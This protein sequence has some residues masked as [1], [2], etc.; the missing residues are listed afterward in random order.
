MCGSHDVCLLIDMQSYAIFQSGIIKVHRSACIDILRRMLLSFHRPTLH[1]NTIADTW[2]VKRTF[3]YLVHSEILSLNLYSRLV[4]GSI[5]SQRI[6]GKHVD[7]REYSHGNK[8]WLLLEENAMQNQSLPAGWNHD[9][10]WKEKRK[11]KIK[12]TNIDFKLP[13]WRA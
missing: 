10:N 4:R 5:A 1:F 13:E 7:V 11:K 6:D 8:T 3:F 12:T 9:E 2:R